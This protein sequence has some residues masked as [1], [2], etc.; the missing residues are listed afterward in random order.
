VSAK[1]TGLSSTIQ[2]V[3]DTRVEIL[4][5]TD[6]ED[7]A[8][9]HAV[10]AQCSFPYREPAAG[11]RD[12]IRENG[13]LSLIV[14][15]GHLFDQKL[16][17]AVL[18]GI[19]YGAKPRL[20][21]IHLC[22]EAI[23]S[24]SPK[25]HIAD[26]MSAFMRELGL[27]VSGG[28]HGSIARFKEQLNRLAAS[29]IQLIVNQDDHATVM[30]PAPI[31]QKFE[32]WF[33]QD[34]RQRNLWPSEVTLSG[35]FFETLRKHA[36][37]IDARALRALQHSARALDV[38]TWLA[39]RLIR[40]HRKQGDRVSWFS[41]KTQFGPDISDARNFKRHMLIALKQALAVYPSAKVEQVDG[42]LILKKSDPPVKK[43]VF[44]ALPR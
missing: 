35:E 31:I 2:R 8:F 28:T 5:D 1:E 15:S 26:S 17:K 44:P 14:S 42:G 33:P 7:L 16:K 22:T 3:I 36:L 18:Q 20:L 38:Y 24:Q 9:L 41:L 21:M 32:V 30:N 27:N 11:A 29:R 40:V 4:G 23:K 43:K 12:Y 34:P 39:H 10:L 25:I 37:P 19:P 6:T 13:R